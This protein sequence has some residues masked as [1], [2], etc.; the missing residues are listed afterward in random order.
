MLD[1]LI[2][3][4][5]RYAVTIV[6]ALSGLL[7]APSS[8]HLAGF[9]A[10]GLTIDL[11]APKFLSS[12]AASKDS[13]SYDP[14]RA[15]KDGWRWIYC[16]AGVYLVLDYGIIVAVAALSP[17]ST[18]LVGPY[19]FAIASPLSLLLRN[20]YAVLLGDG[21]VARANH[22]A[23]VYAG[24]F[25]V[26]YAALA[27]AFCI[28]RC[29]F[30]DGAALRRKQG[31]DLRKSKPWW[32]TLVLLAMLAVVIGF[33]TYFTTYLQI[34]Y[35]DENLGRRH[36]NLN[37]RD[38]S[39]FFFDLAMFLS[40]ICLLVPFSYHLLRFMLLERRW[41]GTHSDPSEKTL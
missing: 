21:Y 24:Q 9:V 25:V 33:A 6:Y 31:F 12:V 26:F 11:L 35:S 4:I 14:E 3:T 30:A 39:K 29:R 16:L 28:C 13:P 36:L 27:M 38:H 10:V 1:R 23:I 8:I 7:N 2:H 32:Y 5:D 41:L 17:A 34:D 20:H 19:A 40:G 18:D 22:V 15:Y 37:L